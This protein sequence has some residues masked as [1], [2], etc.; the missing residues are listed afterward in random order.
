MTRRQDNSPPVAAI[1]LAAGSATRMGRTK[2]LLP[3]GAGTMLQHTVDQALEAGLSP[4]LV[5]VGADAGAVQASIAA[6]RIEIVANSNWALGMGSSVT[7]GIK[8]LRA[9]G[10]EC[11]AA[12]ILLGDQPLVNAKHLVEMKALLHHVDA[13]IIAAEYNGTLG[14]PAFFKRELFA[15]LETIPADAG[16]RHLLRDSGL[17]IA[18]FPLPEAAIDI[19]TPD[20]FAKLSG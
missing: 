20:D 2:Q 16:A 15:R 7:A 13:P 12:A 8:K 6:K 11:A 1:I 5:V 18:P 10:S 14:V 4:V 9:S 17:K 19:D 3:Y